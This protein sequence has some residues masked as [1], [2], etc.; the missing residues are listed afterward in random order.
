M[1][2]IEYLPSFDDDLDAVLTYYEL[3]YMSPQTADA[4]LN[5][6]DKVA[7]DLSS[8][9]RRYPKYLPMLPLHTDYRVLFIKGNAVFYTV[10]ESTKTVK[11]MRMLNGHMD[12]DAWL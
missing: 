4:I 3:D 5:D 10:E 2:N 8:Y 6:L 9:P 12:F 11:I 1:Y 7:V